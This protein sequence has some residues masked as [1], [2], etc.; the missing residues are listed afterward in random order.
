L[1]STHPPV[2]A[3]AA[4]GLR[5]VTYRHGVVVRITHWINVLCMT[6][7]LMSGLQIFNAHPALY[8]GSISDF[9][10]PAFA[11]RAVQP[12]GGAPQGQML[13]LGFAVPTTGV[14][15]LTHGPDNE[16]VV[17]AFPWWMTIPS[18]YSLADGRQW[19]FFFAWVF[20]LNALVY[21]GHGLLSR[22]LWRDLIPTL[23]DLR[24]LPAAIIEHARLRLPRGEAARRYN[25]LQRL[26]YLAVIFVLVPTIV[27]AGCAM[28]PRL[29]AGFPWLL[30]LF[31][32]RQSA[33][34]VHFI[35]AWSL[36][37]FVVAHVVMVLV[38]GLFNN[39][40]SMVTGRY[41][42]ETAP[43]QR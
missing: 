4:G 38:S 33:R 12:E 2:A 24:H 20:V 14:L 17:R 8:W 3:T 39:M 19:H 31:G 7:L 15:G 32:G 5:V 26:T 42:I 29:D 41:V 18:Y 10:H 23:A 27:L 16:A 9:E 28:S 43:V 25:V 22:H 36:V 11:I 30:T 34:T 40:R 35:A 37:A 21:F 6:V 13:L 1:S